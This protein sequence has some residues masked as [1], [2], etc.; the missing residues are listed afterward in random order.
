MTHCGLCSLWLAQTRT[1]TVLSLV[2][3]PPP[4]VGLGTRLH[5]TVTVEPLNILAVDDFT[6]VSGLAVLF[7][8]PDIPTQQEDTPSPGN[9]LA[10]QTFSPSTDCF[11][12]VTQD[13]GSDRCIST[14]LVAPPNSDDQ[15][16][17]AVPCLFKDRL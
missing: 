11:Q 6:L 12:Y 8:F 17:Y 5:C 13:T 15:Q 9:S 4:G 2:P 14:Y 3:R 1:H 7:N 10:G 16:R